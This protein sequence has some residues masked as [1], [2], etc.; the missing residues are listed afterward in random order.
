[1][2]VNGRPYHARSRAEQDLPALR[3]HHGRGTSYVRFEGWWSTAET[4]GVERAAR[5]I[6]CDHPAAVRHPGGGSAWVCLCFGVG[7]A[8]CFIAHWRRRNEVVVARSS[9]ELIERMRCLPGRPFET[10]GR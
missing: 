7:T 3:Y 9:C 10:T 6:D 5:A 2:A 1:M 8:R 4:H